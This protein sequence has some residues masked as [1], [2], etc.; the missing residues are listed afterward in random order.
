[1]DST[2]SFTTRT[3]RWIVATITTLLWT[4]SSAALAQTARP[5]TPTSDVASLVRQATLA[6][7]ATDYATALSL[8]Q[9]AFS[10]SNDPYLLFNIARMHLL[11]RRYSEA[12]STLQ[13]F[14]ERVPDAPNRGTVD[15]M[16]RDASREIERQRLEREAEEAAQRQRREDE[17][18]RANEAR[19]R[20]VA[21]VALPPRPA[22]PWA[23]VAVAGGAAI[24]AGVSAGLYASA[25][26]DLHN[27][28]ISGCDTSVTPLQCP[29]DSRGSVLFESARSAGGAM[30]GLSIA[31]AA[32]GVGSAVAFVVTT[33]RAE[34]RATVSVNI[35]PRGDAAVIVRG[36]F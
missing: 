5:T 8:Y 14:I 19:N 23:L 15:A 10:S 24:G 29:A 27:R 7:E 17:A 33:P 4:C 31:A 6:H 12:Q 13:R 18:R 36:S 25:A 26:G 9:R 22:W 32:L 34:A 1:M 11:L 21:P 35:D 20:P 2:A 16:L 3:Q 30:V 28:A